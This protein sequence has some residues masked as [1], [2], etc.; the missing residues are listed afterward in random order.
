MIP[1][2]LKFP[3]AQ[4]RPETKLT[5]VPS[6][7]MMTKK[8]STT[9]LHR[10][11]PLSSSCTSSALRSSPTSL[12]SV[13]SSLEFDSSSLVSPPTSMEK[14]HKKLEPT[15]RSKEFWRFEGICP[16]YSPGALQAEA[17]RPCNSKIVIINGSR[18]QQVVPFV[19]RK[20]HWAP[21]KSSPLR[22]V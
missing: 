2:P 10:H 5:F 12:F 22:V 11:R 18:G 15:D 13:S 16:E 4:P 20:C 21:L 8:N 3:P 7:S 1:L 19:S 6:S 9:C 17:A 14:I